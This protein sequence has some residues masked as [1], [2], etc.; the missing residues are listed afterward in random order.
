MPHAS[1]LNPVRGADSSATRSLGPVAGFE[2]CVF[3]R[4]AP[5]PWSQGTD[6]GAP[7]AKQ[8]GLGEKA[9]ITPALRP[10]DTLFTGPNMSTI[11][12]TGLILDPRQ[13]TSR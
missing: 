11:L 4:Q 12:N 5:Q 3:H 1:R 13:I 9:V 2:M 7:A 8:L 6:G 10:V